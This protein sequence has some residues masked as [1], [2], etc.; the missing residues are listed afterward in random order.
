M[1][2]KQ[3]MSSK[4][5]GPGPISRLEFRKIV[6]TLIDKLTDFEIDTVFKELSGDAEA[7][8][9]EDFLNLFRTDEQEKLQY[10]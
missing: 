9:R 6:R 2:I 3:I 10:N 8:A 1:P 5:C 4:N 7:L